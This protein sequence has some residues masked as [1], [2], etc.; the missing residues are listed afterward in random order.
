MAPPRR[1]ARLGT[2]ASVLDDLLLAR[3]AV[4]FARS[5]TDRLKGTLHL[6]YGGE[7]WNAEQLAAIR[8]WLTQVTR[9]VCGD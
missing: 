7:E 9:Q 4:G 6:M 5:G 8:R 2:L 3:D 1:K